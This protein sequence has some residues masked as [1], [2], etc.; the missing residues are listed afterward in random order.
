VVTV[1]GRVPDHRCL[2]EL[3]DLIHHK[4]TLRYED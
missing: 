3:V 4:V 1:R 2:E